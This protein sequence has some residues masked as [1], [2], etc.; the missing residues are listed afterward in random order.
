MIFIKWLT[1]ESGYAMNEGGVPIAA[2]DD[3]LPSIYE[4]FAD[5]EMIPNLPA[6]EGEEDLLADINSESEL[7]IN[8]NGDKKVQGI[9]EHAANHDM[10]FDAI[11][12][13]WNTSWNDA[14]D[15][16]GVEAE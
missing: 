15:T 14:L 6:K 9:V 4:D 5:V 16:L 10:D 2:D 12:E 7:G 13:E 11:M 1:E 3:Q 8:S